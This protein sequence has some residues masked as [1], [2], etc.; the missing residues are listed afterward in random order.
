MQPC[1]RCRLWKLSESEPSDIV[2]ADLRAVSK[3]REVKKDKQR[4]IRKERELR[5]GTNNPLRGDKLVRMGVKHETTFEKIN[6]SEKESSS[7]L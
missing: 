4:K 7:I 1:A 6:H 2:T 3:E 5:Q